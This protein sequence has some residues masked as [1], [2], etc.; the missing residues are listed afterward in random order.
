MHGRT[1][2]VTIL[3]VHPNSIGEHCGIKPGDVILDLLLPRSIQEGNLYERVL[4]ACR[5]NRDSN[6][7]MKLRIKRHVATN[8]SCV[9]TH[10]VCNGGVLPDSMEEG[11]DA[12]E[13]RGDVSIKENNTEDCEH[14]NLSEGEAL[15]NYFLY[16]SDDSDDD[17]SQ[18]ASDIDNSNDDLDDRILADK[19]CKTDLED[20][21]L[22]ESVQVVRQR[23]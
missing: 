5:A 21:T 23:N 17:W 18:S 3:C 4:A 2:T 14:S 16:K 15:V 8:M 12:N 22:S 1:N 20:C 11:I 19:D 6:D 10:A 13:E 9:R 7:P